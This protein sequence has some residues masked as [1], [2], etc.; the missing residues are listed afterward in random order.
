MSKEM[1]DLAANNEGRLGVDEEWGIGLRGD[2][3]GVV[4][5]SL[6]GS[7]EMRPTIEMLESRPSFSSDV[8]E[9]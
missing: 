7:I 8:G 1:S 2:V 9:K 5:T 6:M 4:G 3:S